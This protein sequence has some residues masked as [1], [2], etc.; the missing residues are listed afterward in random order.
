[1]RLPP[2]C[3]EPRLG[4][5][6]PVPGFPEAGRPD[7]GLAPVCAVSCSAALSG[8]CDFRST[9]LYRVGRVPCGFAGLPD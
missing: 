7:A 6:M 9:R 1:M 2:S 5:W 3:D 8:C 4:G